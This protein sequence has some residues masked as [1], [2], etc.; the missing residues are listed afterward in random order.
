MYKID[1]SVQTY[2]WGRIGAESSVSVFKAA[3]NADF[4]IDPNERY[5]ELWMGKLLNNKK[6][7][8]S[9]REIIS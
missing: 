2:D 8:I 9:I 3:M 4:Q 1:C 5:A 7:T 6:L